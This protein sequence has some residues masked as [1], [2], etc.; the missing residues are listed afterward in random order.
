MALPMAMENCVNEPV[1]YTLQLLGIINV[2][3][4]NVSLS[5][6]INDSLHGSVGVKNHMESFPDM[7]NYRFLNSIENRDPGLQYHPDPLL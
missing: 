3:T 7:P 4:T 5:R 2:K 6:T 1:G